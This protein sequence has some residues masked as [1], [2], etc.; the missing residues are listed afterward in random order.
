MLF[1][2]WLSNPGFGMQGRVERV[3]YIFYNYLSYSTI[4]IC[5]KHSLDI[6]KGMARRVNKVYATYKNTQI[7]KKRL[8]EEKKLQI[9]LSDWIEWL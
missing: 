2:L 3:S 7:I 9:G 8:W 4:L 5:T 6:A 1:K